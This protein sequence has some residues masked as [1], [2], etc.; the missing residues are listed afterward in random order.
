MNPDFIK[1]ISILNMFEICLGHSFK[2][3]NQFKGPDNFILNFISLFYKEVLKIILV[4]NDR[5]VFLFIV[6]ASKLQ[7]VVLKCNFFFYIS[8]ICFRNCYES[9]N[10]INIYNWVCV[11]TNSEL[12]RGKVQEE[13]C[14]IGIKFLLF[15]NPGVKAKLSKLSIS[16][17]SLSH[18]RIPF[19]YK[20]N[21]IDINTQLQNWIYSV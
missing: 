18:D 3:F 7:N 9:S 13:V 12:T 4:K 5:T 14:D 10:K 19:V 17:I 8:P 21:Q 15:K 20:S 1:T 16:I 6:H 11:R 2:F